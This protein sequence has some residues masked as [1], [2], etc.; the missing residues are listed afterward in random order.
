MNNQDRDRLLMDLS[1]HEQVVAVEID[2]DDLVVRL[3]GEAI[4]VT[5]DAEFGRTV[6]WAVVRGVTGSASAAV[7]EAAARFNTEHLSR[8]T[9]VLCFFVQS[10]VLLM[11]KSIQKA[12]MSADDVVRE[13]LDLVASLASA[14]SFV[15]IALDHRVSGPAAMPEVPAMM[16]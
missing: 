6:V 1:N 8:S 9:A 4:R 15:E 3:T 10:S 16:A 2:G 7:A 14:R 5:T 11:G 12:S 13:A